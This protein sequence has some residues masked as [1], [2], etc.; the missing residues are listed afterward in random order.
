MASTKLEIITTT[1]TIVANQNTQLRF[2]TI[3]TNTLAATVNFTN[4]GQYNEIVVLSDATY[5]IVTSMGFGG[6][7]LGTRRLWIDVQYD[8]LVAWEMVAG[9][10]TQ[11]NITGIQSTTIQA[12]VYLRAGAKIR[13]M[14]WADVSGTTTVVQNIA[15]FTPKTSLAVT[16]SM[17]LP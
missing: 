17:P 14:T 16:P 13:A 10:Y 5:H 15:N 8:A 3:A 6:T 12:T 1:Y 2:D 9:S 11:G 7:A 4:A